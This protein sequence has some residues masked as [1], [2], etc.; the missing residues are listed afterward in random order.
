MRGVSSNPLLSDIQATS[1]CPIPGQG[2]NVSAA[3]APQLSLCFS[4]PKWNLPESQGTGQQQ[5]RWADKGYTVNSATPATGTAVPGKQGRGKSWEQWCVSWMWNEPLEITE[6]EPWGWDR[7][8]ERDLSLRIE[9]DPTKAAGVGMDQATNTG[10]ADSPGA[11]GIPLWYEHPP[12][13]WQK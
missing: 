9:A 4:A 11:G 5:T 2:V 1:A 12:L 6:F 10:T 3:A 8:S 13:P 7:P